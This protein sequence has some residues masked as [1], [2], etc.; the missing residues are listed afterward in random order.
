MGR[1]KLGAQVL[2]PSGP[3]AVT[4]HCPQEEG[5]RGWPIG[6]MGTGSGLGTLH[7]GWAG[8]WVGVRSEALHLLARVVGDGR[9]RGQAGPGVPQPRWEP[10]LQG[11]Q[12]EF[13]G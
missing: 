8:R 2:L 7:P 10:C 6:T 9:P 11:L 1:S 5:T 3:P 4:G 13:G 12:A